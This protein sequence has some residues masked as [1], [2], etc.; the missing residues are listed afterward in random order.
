MTDSQTSNERVEFEQWLLDAHGLSD[1]WDEARNCYKQFAAH[2]A[3][4]AWLARAS[5]NATAPTSLEKCPSELVSFGKRFVCCL[6]KG[7]PTC[8]FVP[9]DETSA[10]QVCGDKLYLN[11]VQQVCVKPAGHQ[12]H[13]YRPAVEP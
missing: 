2:L 9:A 10:V 11:A 7:H 13:D 4:K 8:Q 5:V 6:P 1:E 12:H 3:W